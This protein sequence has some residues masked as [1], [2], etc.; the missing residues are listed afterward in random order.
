[1]ARPRTVLIVVLA[2]IS[3]LALGCKTAPPG[4]TGTGGTQAKGTSAQ[5]QGS[6][7]SRAA[8][9]TSASTSTS[10]GRQATATGS[11]SRTR[12]TAVAGRGTTASRLPIGR[13]GTLQTLAN[14]YR[15]VT[16]R[17]VDTFTIVENAIAAVVV[18]GG[19]GAA[20][21]IGVR[22]HRRMASPADSRR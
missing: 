18:L 14:L 9:G 4:E 21:A 13:G 2:A 17:S 11:T 12:S 20:I 15:A 16:G 1:M 6:S 10:S 8:T 7:S 3:L 22:R 19:I 5:S